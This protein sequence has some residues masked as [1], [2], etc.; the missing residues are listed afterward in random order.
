MSKQMIIL[1]LA[2]FGT[3]GYLKNAEACSC[4]PDNLP[5]PI[6]C[7]TRYLAL[8]S[9]DRVE[10]TDHHKQ[11]H[12]TLIKDFGSLRP[13]T[14]N[15]ELNHTG[16]IETNPSSASCGVYLETGINYLLGGTGPD[17]DGNP[18]LSL[19]HFY[20]KSWGIDENLS[21]ITMNIELLMKRC[22]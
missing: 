1:T 7:R 9:I 19:C 15:L 11:Y 21:N 10:E 16:I 6:Y 12:Y 17:N 2:L 5:T 18:T 8:V 14:N 22:K 13:N 20:S 3:L 4:L